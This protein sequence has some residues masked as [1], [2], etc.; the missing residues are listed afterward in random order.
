[1]SEISPALL[2]QVFRQK[3][4]QEKAD[5][6]ERYHHLNRFVRK[7]QVV[8]AGSSL[9][10]QFPL[11][12]FLLDDALPYTLYNRGIGG[13]T[14]TEMLAALDACIFELEPSHLFLNIGTN[15]LNVPDYDQSAMLARYEE[16]LRAVTARLPGVQLHLLAYYPVN[17]EK[18][19][20]PA[21]KAAFRC[22]TN[23]R[24]AAANAGVRALAQRY[25][26]EFLDLNEGLCDE[27]GNL[28]ADFTIEGVH[29]YADGYRVVWKNLLPALERIA[30]Q[31][32]RK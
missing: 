3:S 25:G 11:Y 10:E 31:L 6:V 8:F 23:A 9:M 4:Q 13:F 15:D 21:V 30:A 17:P 16:I 28:N 29:M 19:D 14:T 20:S 22:R 12:E 24:I 1:M 7:G 18:T 2:E 5:K 26:A 27:A 32:N